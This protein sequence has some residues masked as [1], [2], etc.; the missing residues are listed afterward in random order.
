MEGLHMKIKKVLFA[1]AVILCTVNFAS[2]DDKIIKEIAKQNHISIAKVKKTIEKIA[3]DEQISVAEV[4]KALETG[5]DS[6]GTA[7]MTKCA[8][9]HFMIVDIKMNDIYTRVKKLLIT[10]EARLKLIKAQRAWINFRDTVCEYESEG[11][12]GGSGYGMV[13]V[14]CLEQYTK[15]RIKNLQGYLDC[16]DTDCLGLTQ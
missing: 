16:K 5:C 4:K 2:A 10:K 3:S 14:G 12:S 11:W 1:L 7:S 9:Y 15:E 8:K 6:G 13:Y